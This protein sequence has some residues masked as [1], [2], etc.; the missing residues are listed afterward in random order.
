MPTPEKAKVSPLLTGFLRFGRLAIALAQ[1]QPPKG[2][3]A[4]PQAQLDDGRRSKAGREIHKQRSS[5][6]E[7]CRARTSK[8]SSLGRTPIVSR[9]GCAFSSE[10]FGNLAQPRNDVS[11]RA[12]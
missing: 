9:R 10:R 11:I 12:K 3:C 7:D 8:M 2:V 5:R 4:S 1:N 6:D